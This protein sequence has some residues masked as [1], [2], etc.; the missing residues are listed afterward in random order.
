MEYM[1]ISQAAEKWGISSRRIQ[2][3]CKQERIPGA[4]RMGY[5]WAIPADA[6]KPR[7]ARVKSGKY[8]RLTG[9]N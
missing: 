5:V 7:D 3:L 1:S 2:V 9:K 6:E 8:V 4:S